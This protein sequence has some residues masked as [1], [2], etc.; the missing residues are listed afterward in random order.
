MSLKS[1]FVII[2]LLLVFSN[3]FLDGAVSDSVLSIAFD[4]EK[5][6]QRQSIICLYG[7]MIWPPVS[8]IWGLTVPMPSLDDILISAGIASGI[9]FFLQLI[10]KKID[11]KHA[12]ALYGLVWVLLKYSGYLAIQAAGPECVQCME[13]I[14][15][16]AD[17]MYAVFGVLG[18]AALAKI[19]IKLKK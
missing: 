18:V 10:Q 12:L 7:L 14:S 8:E 17:G 2:G 4:E 11:W 6:P 1:A 15:A 5:A 16:L 3:A 19:V 13:D 9:L